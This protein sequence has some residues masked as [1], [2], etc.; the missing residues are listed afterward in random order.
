FNFRRDLKP[1]N[2]GLCA[3]GHVKVFD[4]GLSVVQETREG[5]INQKY[6]MS[7]MAGSKRFMSPEVCNGLPYN[8]KV[9]VYSFAIVLWELCAL[10]KPFKGMSVADHYREVISGGL[11]PPLDPRWPAGLRHLLGA[12][13]HENPD[14]RPSI[15][16]VGDFLRQLIVAEG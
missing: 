4:L 14:R 2:I 8:E 6:Q 11:R 15:A 9:D 12:C 13:W 5:N 3:A 10:H 16:E 7:G 1:T